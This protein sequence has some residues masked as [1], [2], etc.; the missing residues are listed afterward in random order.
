MKIKITMQ[1]IA[2]HVGYSRSMVSRALTGKSRI[3]EETRQIIREAAIQMGYPEEKILKK[4]NPQTITV[5]TDRNAM[6][7]SGYCNKV[8]VGIENGL[9]VHG[10]RM[11][12]HLI[13]ESAADI[14]KDS[15]PTKED[16]AGIILFLYTPRDILDQVRKSGIPT[17]LLNYTHMGNK[18]FD[19]V[20][21]NDFVSMYDA[22]DYLIAKGHKR[23]FYVGS[24]YQAYSY[25]QRFYG[26]WEC[27]NHHTAE[28]IRAS[29]NCADP[30]EHQFDPERII[31]ALKGPEAPTAI[32]CA[33]D[34]LAFD[35]YTAITDHGFRIPEDVSVIGFDDV[36]KA[37]WVQPQLTTVHVP[38]FHLGRVAA[39]II[40]E[41]INNPGRHE[42]RTVLLGTRFV[43]R[44]SVRVLVENEDS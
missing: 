1:D 6:Y 13:G 23:L 41:R 31:S 14:E 2:D 40:A 24:E 5:L 19:H 36:E 11:H 39:D 32:V 10:L 34:P 21:I 20:L 17:V 33:S 9:K 28:G 22:T 25:S 37:T 35:V 44:N 42:N 27:I 16:T 18:G 8:F 7:D 4:R 12:L 3:N 38:K 30:A 29:V 15:F 26:F 43:E